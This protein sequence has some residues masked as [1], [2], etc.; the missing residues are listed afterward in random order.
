MKKMMKMSL[1]MALA[2]LL[3]VGCQ[4]D[5]TH[6]PEEGQLTTVTATI[7]TNNAGRVVYDDDGSSVLKVNWKESGEEFWVMGRGLERFEQ[8]AGSTFTGVLDGGHPLFDNTYSAVYPITYMNEDYE[9]TMDYTQQSGVLDEQFNYMETEPYISDGTHFEFRQM[10]AIIKPTFKVAGEKVNN[11]ISEITLLDVKGAQPG[12]AK[13]DITI[14]CDQLETI[15]IYLPNGP[16][17]FTNP[18][19]LAAGES[20]AL[21]VTIGEELYLG[22]ITVPEGRAIEMGKVYPLGITLTKSAPAA[23]IGEAVDLGLSVAWATYNVGATA[24]EEYGDYFNWGEVEPRPGKNDFA[25]FY[26]YS[27]GLMAAGIIDA[28]YNLTTNYDAAATNWGGDWRMPTA[29]EIDELITKCTWALSTLN[30]VAGITV[31]GPNGNS[32][33]LPTAGRYNKFASRPES[34]GQYGNYWSG[35]AIENNDR[36]NSPI[37]YYQQ[38]D[39]V[40]YTHYADRACGLPIRPVKPKP[41][42]E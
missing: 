38:S 25:T 18:T 7:N 1:V 42:R 5:S 20:I 12:V 22:R 32:I 13:A 19:I 36:V 29:K 15:Y 41:I 39:A 2:A 9:V 30:S 10:T 11:Q 37:L 27:D 35:T 6:A 40:H 28:N 31:T 4:K 21:E 34:G 23:T 26:K 17:W 8:V 24:P 16:A 3:A 14:T 33:F